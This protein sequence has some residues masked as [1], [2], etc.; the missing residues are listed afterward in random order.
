M[1]REREGKAEGEK[2]DPSASRK[3][4]K[5][6]REKLRRDRLNEHFQELGNTLG[7]LLRSTIFLFVFYN[8][9]SGEPFIDWFRIRFKRFLVLSLNFF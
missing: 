8:F 1:C 2:E 7:A 9:A 6:D 3:V 5:A 4:L